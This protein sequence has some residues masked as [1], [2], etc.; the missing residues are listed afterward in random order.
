MAYA[1]ARAGGVA[2]TVMNAANE[3]AV[4]RFLAG[5]GRFIDIFAT[6]ERALGEAPQIPDAS[7]DDIIAADAEVRRRL[8][9]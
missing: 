1:A 3:M 6:V 5:H 9:G 4:A 8:A 7:L 2:P